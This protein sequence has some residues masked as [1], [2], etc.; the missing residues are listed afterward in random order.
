MAR[1][2]TAK[3]R[4]DLLD[5]PQGRLKQREIKEWREKLVAQ[6]FHLCPLCGLKLNKEDAVLDHC[7]KTGLIRGA[8]HSGCNAM[9]GKL[10]NAH[11]RMGKMFSDDQF[12]SMAPSSWYYVTADYSE[13]PLHPT[14]RTQEEKRLSRNERAKEK[15]KKKAK[16]RPVKKPGVSRT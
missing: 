5:H 4:D 1:G 12:M 8:L 15:R 16:K 13:M 6:Q 7:H 3:R 9:L 14:W 2:K 11:V 10:E